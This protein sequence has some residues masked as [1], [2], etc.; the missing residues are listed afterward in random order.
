[1]SEVFNPL[2][3]ALV[4]TIAAGMQLSAALVCEFVKVQARDGEIL[5]ITEDSEQ[6][7]VRSTTIGLNCQG[8][9]Y[10]LDN[11]RMWRISNLFSLVALAVGVTT[12]LIAWSG[13]ISTP[14]LVLWKVMAL[15]ASL[16]ALLQVPTFVVFESY[17]CSGF[18]TQQEC[19]LSDGSYFLILS[20]VSWIATTAVTQFLDPPQWKQKLYLWRIPQNRTAD[21][22]LDEDEEAAPELEQGSEDPIF[23]SGFQHSDV[24]MEQEEG[25]RVLGRVKDWF[26][27]L[28]NEE[29]SPPDPPARVVQKFSFT[30][31]SPAVTAADNQMGQH[32]THASVNSKSLNNSTTNDESVQDDDENADTKGDVYLAWSAFPQESGV[33][34]TQSTMSGPHLISGDESL[35]DTSTGENSLVDA[36]TDTECAARS[37]NKTSGEANEES[38]LKSVLEEEAK[39]EISAAALSQEVDEEEKKSDSP[40]G[41]EEPD[42][43]GFVPETKAESTPSRGF[44]GRAQPRGQRYQRMLDHDDSVSP[45]RNSPPMTEV[46][47]DKN[48]CDE[49]GA[50]SS[51][52]RLLSDW[53]DMFDLERVVPAGGSD[54]GS[55]RDVDDMFDADYAGP[56]STSEDD[57]EPDPYLVSSEFQE[58]D[59]SNSAVDNSDQGSAEKNARKVLR[60]ARS[61]RKRPTSGSVSSSHSLLSYTIEEETEEDLQKDSIENQ[62]QNDVSR[63][64]KRSSSTPPNLDRGFGMRSPV[65]GVAEEV[66]MVG[67]NA[68]RVVELCRQPGDQNESISGNSNDRIDSS[69]S[70]LCHVNKHAMGDESK[71]IDSNLRKRRSRSLELPT[72]TRAPIE[73]SIW[74]A[75]RESKAGIHRTPSYVSSGESSA[76]D[77]CTFSRD[78]IRRARVHRL[79]NQRHADLDTSIERCGDL[80]QTGSLTPVR[81][82]SRRTVAVSPEVNS[83]DM[84]VAARSDIEAPETYVLD[85]VDA[86]LAQLARDTDEEYGSEEDSI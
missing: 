83:E 86:S 15:A 66:T 21:T 63:S 59:A 28:A 61:W 76:D 65:R 72:R 34:E 37:K 70:G 84:P 25:K 6:E 64:S 20:V 53:N 81:D 3:A 12:F 55:Y 17:P 23:E 41:D 58:M 57:S 36:G 2:V 32:S 50:D 80:M 79:Q 35:L 22:T 56:P 42:S 73:T 10:N 27:R 18:Q 46:T 52:Q 74:K 44:F 29:D 9:F 43:K 33:M 4:S 19:K 62:G 48:A 14:T 40:H 11:D 85:T 16:S 30:T 7:A 77:E 49:V 39:V 68:F 5:A 60:P 45:E 1:M 82:V 67:M 8:D 38:L 26:E 54:D 51:V 69:G 31:M 13:V 24:W 75:E 71:A 78:K 47:I